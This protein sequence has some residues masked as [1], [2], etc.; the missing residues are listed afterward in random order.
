[1]LH[2]I[3]GAR[4]AIGNCLARELINGR[5]NV[6]LVSRTKFEVGPINSFQADLLSLPDTIEALKGSEVAYLCVGLNYSTK[7]WQDDWPTIMYN[8]ISAC[9][10]NNTKLIFFDNVYMYGKVEG[11]MTEETPYNPC[12]KKGEVR[13][14]IARALETEMENGN[15]KALIA[16]SADLYGPYISSNSIPF[17]MVFQQLLYGKKA[18]WI[19]NANVPHSFTYTMDTA[20]SMY[21]LSQDDDNYGQVWHIPTCSPSLTGKEFV[22]IVATELNQSTKV[23]EI[24]KIFMWIGGF[25]N[26]IVKENLEMTYQYEYPYI[27]DSSKYENKYNRAPTSYEQGIKDTITFIKKIAQAYHTFF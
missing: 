6:R 14:K 10:E 16:R 12:S 2:T 21:R 18:D 15:I 27:F 11:K 19:I 24:K 4:G 25:L 22:E 26:P 3:L 9:K 17:V 8:V 1:M 13:A 20:K 7:V 5:E 23:T